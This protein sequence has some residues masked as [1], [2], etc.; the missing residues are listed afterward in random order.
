MLTKQS[1]FQLNIYYLLYLFWVTL[2]FVLQEKAM[3]TA[4]IKR[5]WKREAEW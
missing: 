2:T 3:I 4:V 5:K 1:T